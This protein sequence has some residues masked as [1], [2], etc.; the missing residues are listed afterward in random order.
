[1]HFYKC[2]WEKYRIKMNCLYYPEN[3]SMMNTRVLLIL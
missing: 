3:M 2:L 1:M